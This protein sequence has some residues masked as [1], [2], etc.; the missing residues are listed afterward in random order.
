MDRLFSVGDDGPASASVST[1]ISSD[2]PVLDPL[3]VLASFLALVSIPASVFPPSP[4]GSAAKPPRLG[5][6]PHCPQVGYSSF[7]S[8]D[9]VPA[10]NKDLG[11]SSVNGHGLG[12]RNGK[13]IL[14]FGQGRGRL[15]R[16]RSL[17]GSVGRGTSRQGGIGG[18]MIFKVWAMD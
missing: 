6:Q 14:G 10:Q 13:W 1:H 7:G 4:I 12:R 11:L 8:T 18:V 17:S 15:C 2:V 5:G 16:A 9:V 3:P